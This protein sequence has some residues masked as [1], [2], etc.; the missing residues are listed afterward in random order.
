MVLLKV[1]NQTLWGQALI[2]ICVKHLDSICRAPLLQIGML[3]KLIIPV[4]I[5]MLCK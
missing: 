5:S 3:E 4:F 1:I 2:S